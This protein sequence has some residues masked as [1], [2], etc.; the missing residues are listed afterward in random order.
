MQILSSV[1]VAFSEFWS[2]SNRQ[3][4]AKFFTSEQCYQPLNIRTFKPSKKELGPK[5]NYETPLFTSAAIFV[6]YED[7]R[8]K[9]E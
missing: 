4:L 1:S 6:R 2:K 3:D 7:S 8:P 5:L 9:N